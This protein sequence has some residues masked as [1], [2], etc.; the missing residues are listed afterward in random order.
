MQTNPLPQSTIEPVRWGILSTGKIAAKFAQALEICTSGKAVAVASRD[1]AKANAFAKSWNVARAYGCYEALLA[2]PEIEAVYIATPHPQHKEWTIQAAR[3]GKHIL[4]EKPLALNLQEGEEMVRA[5]KDN[6]VLLMEA[7][8]Y[9]CH[10]QTRQVVDLVRDGALGRLHMIQASFGFAAPYDANSRIWNPDAAGGA[11][12]DV[13]CYPVS[14]SRLMAGAALDLP[15]A[16]PETLQGCG[17]L[18]PSSS[19]DEWATATL[20]FDHDIVA[21]LATA[22]SLQLENTVRLTGDKGW[23]QI[24]RPWIINP[25]GEDAEIVLHRYETGKTENLHISAAPLYVL[26][27]DAFAQAVRLGKPNVAAMTPEDSLGNLATLDRWRE[28]LGLTYQIEKTLPS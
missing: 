10:P 27:A 24:P 26:E 2:D 3:A 15:F 18:H 7:F 11:I 25:G 16:N 14:M 21:Q 20:R 8:M 5:A 17:K 19:V 23:L 13:G 6:H 1:Q 12:L 4:C 28:T 22:I 9:R